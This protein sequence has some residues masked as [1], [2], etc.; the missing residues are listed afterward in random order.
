MEDTQIS[1]TTTG[2]ESAIAPAPVAVKPAPTTKP[3]PVVQEAAQPAGEKFELPLDRMNDDERAVVKAF[4]QLEGPQK[5]AVLGTTSFTEKDVLKGRSRV[6][7]ALRRLTKGE[8]VEQFGRG[9]YKLTASG[10]RRSKKLS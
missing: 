5:I 10:K 1:Q 9:T 4:T 8:W 2:T 3:A 7:N 6:R